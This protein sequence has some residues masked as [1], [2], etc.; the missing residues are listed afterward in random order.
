MVQ[1]R[2]GS[3]AQKQE[4]PSTLGQL[5]MKCKTWQVLHLILFAPLSPLPRIKSTSLLKKNKR[6][7][8]TSSTPPFSPQY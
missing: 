5:N 4:V 1:N 8:N 7:Q 6:L 3:L 2:Y